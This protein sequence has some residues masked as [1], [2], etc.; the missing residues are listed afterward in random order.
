MRGFLVLSLIVACAPAAVADCVGPVCV[1]EQGYGPTDCA[2]SGDFGYHE[3]WVGL[4]GTPTEAQVGGNSFC[5]NGEE[6]GQFHADTLYASGAGV[7]VAWSSTS[8]GCFVY[9]FTATSTLFEPCP[10]GV[11]PPNPGWGRVLP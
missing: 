7:Y 11:E 9:A 1:V 5:Y 2:A 3:T 8:S 6:T 4:V 10:A